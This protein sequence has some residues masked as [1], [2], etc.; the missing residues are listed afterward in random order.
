MITHYN[1]IANLLQVGTFESFL[2]SPGGPPEPA[3]GLLPFSHGYGLLVGHLAVWRGDPLVSFPRFDMQRMLQAVQ[4]YRIARLYL[5]PPILVALATNPFLAELF[6]LSSVTSL[7]S[8]A[9]P[10]DKTLSGKLKELQPRWSVLAA[11]GTLP[12]LSSKSKPLS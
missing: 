4:Q 3:T 10:L 12:H 11:Y 7:V 5:V 2:R 1:L 6:D 9:A 8:G